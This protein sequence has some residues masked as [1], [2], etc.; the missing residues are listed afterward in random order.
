[1][2]TMTRDVRWWLQKTGNMGKSRVDRVA[3]RAGCP[4][5]KS[6]PAGEGEAGNA[7]G[8]RALL[9]RPD[10]TRAT[11]QKLRPAVRADR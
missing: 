3:I 1:M 6:Y 4:Y 5:R 8:S 10:G 2:A 9:F 11:P 7:G